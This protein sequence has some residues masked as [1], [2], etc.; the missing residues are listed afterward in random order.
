M[1]FLLLRENLKWPLKLKMAAGSH[2]DLSTFVLATLEYHVVAH[3]RLIWV[4]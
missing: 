2:L 1:G 4:Y 3:C